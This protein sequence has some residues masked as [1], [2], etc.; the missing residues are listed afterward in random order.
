MIYGTAIDERHGIACG[1]GSAD[2][3]G[4]RNDMNMPENGLVAVV[5]RD[6]PTCDLL[7]PVY[8]Q[9]SDG[10]GLTAFS[11]D[12]PSFPEHLGGA[13]DHP[14]RERSYQPRIEPAPTDRE[15]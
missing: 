13:P 9:L 10:P 3:P 5:K 6:C 12:E 4:R 14:H 8:R 7:G 2:T 1:R 11:Q 15:N